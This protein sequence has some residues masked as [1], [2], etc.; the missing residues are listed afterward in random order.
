MQAQSELLTRC[1]CA[2]LHLKAVQVVVYA[3]SGGEHDVGGNERSRARAEREA[4]VRVEH[5]L[6]GSG[7]KAV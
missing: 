5:V 1:E 6:Q 4:S 7:Q 3:V 2:R